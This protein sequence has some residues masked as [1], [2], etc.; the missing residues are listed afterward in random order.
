[1]YTCI[2]LLYM[3]TCVQ[4]LLALH[5]CA[6]IRAHAIIQTLSALRLTLTVKSKK[7]KEKKKRNDA[8]NSNLLIK[9]KQIVV[10]HK[11]PIVIY[12]GTA[13]EQYEY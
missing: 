5:R 8:G 11:L 3:Y 7:K 4:L 2:T 13:I 6:S 12:E 10:L 1:M 9:L